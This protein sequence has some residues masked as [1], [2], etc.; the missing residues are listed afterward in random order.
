MFHLTF[1]P[2]VVWFRMHNTI[3]SLFFLLTTSSYY[4]SCAGVRDIA[5]VSLEVVRT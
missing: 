5:V 2:T 4:L 3:T 1:F